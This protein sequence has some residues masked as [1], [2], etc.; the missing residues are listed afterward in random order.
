M[1]PDLPGVI[2]ILAS[3]PIVHFR[4]AS[5]LHTRIRFFLDQAEV[6]VVLLFLSQEFEVK[7]IFT[8]SYWLIVGEFRQ[9]D[10]II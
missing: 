7:A 2:S 4:E 1:Q 5:H 8:D 9:I 10:E 3:S 6:P